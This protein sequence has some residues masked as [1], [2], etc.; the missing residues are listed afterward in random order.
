VGDVLRLDG[1][2]KKISDASNQQST[3]VRAI[4][5]T[6]VELD[7]TTQQNAAL[8]EQGAAAASSMR[9]ESARLVS[10]VG[11]FRTEVALA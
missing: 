9:Q 2:V 5:E 3:S 10:A 8:V 11:L 1:L 4:A 6:L 7:T